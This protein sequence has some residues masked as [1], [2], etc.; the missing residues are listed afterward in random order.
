MNRFGFV[1][2]ACLVVLWLP[3]VVSAG[4]YPEA[5]GLT[6][7]PTNPQLW[8]T[9]P[10]SDSEDYAIDWYAHASEDMANW[11]G[12]VFKSHMLDTSEVD[13]LWITTFPGHLSQ[14]TVAGPNANSHAVTATWWHPDATASGVTMSESDVTS[15][16][17][18]RWDFKAAN[19]TVA[20]NS[21]AD[22]SLIACNIF[23]LAEG[24]TMTLFESD[25]VWATSGSNPVQGEPFPEN[26]PHPD[27]PNGLWQHVAF[28]T[29]YT[30]TA[31]FASNFYATFSGATLV[32]VD[33]VPEPATALLLVAGGCA[34]LMFAWRARRRR[35]HG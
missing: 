27:N 23:H 30:V 20:G 2:V 14:T 9:R 18:A 5:N 4:V 16:P 33:H 25:Y 21:D 10:L 22:L 34:A 19:T 6:Q 35:R 3:G 17:F 13:S 12:V 7:D 24:K 8:K 29:V 31:P 11:A 15:N 32:G 28:T 26:P 1:L